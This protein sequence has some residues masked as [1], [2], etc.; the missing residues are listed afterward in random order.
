MR[1]WYQMIKLFIIIGDFNID[2]LK[3]KT[4]KISQDF[5][6]SLQ[7]YYLIPTV[8]KPTRVYRASATL[9]DNI[10][11][12]NPDKLLAS[13][14]IIFLNSVLQHLRETKSNKLNLLKCETI[15]NFPLTALLEI[16]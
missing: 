13:G 8:D 6:L 12:N 7:S 15:Q 5:L 4:S 14:N 11:V 1:K 16:S 10:F 9:I 3:C 2:L